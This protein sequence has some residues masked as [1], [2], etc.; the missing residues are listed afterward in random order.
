MNIYA[1]K[2]SADLNNC[3]F[4]SIVLPKAYTKA[5]LNLKPRLNLE[6]AEAC[7]RNAE[8]LHLFQK[9]ISEETT[10]G[11]ASLKPG[12]APSSANASPTKVTTNSQR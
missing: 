10:D 3:S 9:K 5:L 1:S 7:L 8:V 2:R 11:L 4:K 12:S 6:Y